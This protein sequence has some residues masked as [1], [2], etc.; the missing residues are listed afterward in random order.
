MFWLPMQTKY[1]I[2]SFKIIFLNQKLENSQF[3][4]IYKL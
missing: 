2:K 1:K 3:R 4:I